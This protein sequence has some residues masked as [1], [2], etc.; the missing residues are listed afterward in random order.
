MKAQGYDPRRSLTL[1]WGEPTRPGRSGLSVRRIVAA[2]VKRADREGIDALSM[3]NLASDL[4]VATMALYTH[5]P[6]TEELLDLVF[7]GV[8]AELYASTAPAAR[9]RGWRTGM[10]FVAEQNWQLYRRHPW[11]LDLGPR[12][13]LG[14]STVR[15]YDLELGPLDGIGL[16]FV[17]MNEALSLVTNHVVGLARIDAQLARERRRTGLSDAEWWS[18]H[19]PTMAEVTQLMPYRLAARVGQAAAEAAS[20]LFDPA[21]ALSFGLDRILDGLGVLIDSRAKKPGRA[22]P[23]PKK[24][25]ATR[26]ANRPGRSASRNSGA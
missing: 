15:K 13:A 18:R 7:D 16:S 23:N 9:R 25:P 26:R 12:P 20:G 17:E 2:A 5:V 11:L 24:A 19:Q 4:G 14:P 10:R 6:G 3:R 1:L 22:S 8:L 21:L